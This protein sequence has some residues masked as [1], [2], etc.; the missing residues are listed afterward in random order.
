M[1]QAPKWTEFPKYPV[2]VGTGL[3]AIGVTVAWWAKMDISPLLE[4]AMIRRGELWRLVTSIFPHVGVLHLIFNL[5]WLWVFGTLVEQVYGHFKTAALILLFAVGANALEYAFSSGGVGLSGVGYGLFG[6]LWILSKRDEHFRDAV[7][8]RTIQLFVIWFFFCIFATATNFM[9]VGNVAHGAGG[10]LGILTGFALTVPKRRVAITVG[11]GLIL[12][13]SLWA[14]TAGRA[15][16][17]FSVYASYDECK[18]GYDAMRSNHNEEALKWL[19][20]AAS[21]HANPASCVTDLGYTYQSMGKNTQAFAE[22]RKAADKGDDEGEYYSAKM[23]E[24]GDGTPKDAKQAVYWYRKAADQG[25]AD[26]LNNVAW[27]FATSSE[28]GVRNPEAALEYAQKAVKAE[29]GDPRP[30]IL[31]TLA[32]AYYVNGQYKNAVQTEKRAL[33]LVTAQEKGNYVTSLEK[34][35]IALA[36]SGQTVIAK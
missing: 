4:D 24:S 33:E 16:V 8:Q 11:I 34:Y 13:V 22:Y 1:R 10:V 26:Q 7:D 21:Y 29:K 15:K 32:E 31:D 2:T 19:Q 23:Y 20:T 27:A 12:G 3:L 18:R 35:Q 17:N 5:Y 30:H 28:P 14:A 9:R 25:S 36:G 6:L